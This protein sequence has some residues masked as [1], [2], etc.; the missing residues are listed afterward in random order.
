MPSSINLAPLL[1]SI[2]TEKSTQPFAN[3]SYNHRRDNT[4]VYVRI[5]VVFKMIRRFDSGFLAC[6]GLSY[7]SGRFSETFSLNSHKPED[8][9]ASLSRPVFILEIRVKW[10]SG[11]LLCWKFHLSCTH[12]KRFYGIYESANLDGPLLIHYDSWCLKVGLRSI[13]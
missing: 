12:H 10:V 2:T 9:E 1:H 13:V 6:S 7:P 4:A 3:L 5:S 11:L 8:R